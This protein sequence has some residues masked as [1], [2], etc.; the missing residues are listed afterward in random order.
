MGEKTYID[1][2]GY[3]RSHPKKHSG[4]VHRQRAYYGIYLPNKEKYPYPFP[5]YEI[6]HKDGDK[7]NNKISNLILLSPEEHDKEHDFFNKYGIWK[8]QFY[9]KIRGLTKKFGE[10]ESKVTTMWFRINREII[11][12]FKEGEARKLAEDPKISDYGF[13]Q[14]LDLKLKE[15]AEVSWRRV[16]EKLRQERR[17]QKKKRKKKGV[18]NKFFNKEIS[19]NLKIKKENYHERMERIIKECPHA[20]QRWTI[21]EE[22]NLLKLFEKK[23]SQKEIARILKRQPSGIRARL[24]KLGKINFL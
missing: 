11:R 22:D 2:D 23:I 12:H 4:A 14:F 20:Y 17:D 19:D 3:E 9:R 6:H 24:K 15:L 13:K 21:E 8:E 7:I 10:K 18:G 1:K 5:Y 16:Q